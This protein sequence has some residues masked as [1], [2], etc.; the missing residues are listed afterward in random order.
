MLS[1]RR[2]GKSW[3]GGPSRGRW[4]ALYP[5]PWNTGMSTYCVHTRQS[6]E[7]LHKWSSEVET[8]APIL[9]TRKHM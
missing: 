5:Y 2:P 8:V 4:T 3:A 7:S 9:Y 6:C 1:E